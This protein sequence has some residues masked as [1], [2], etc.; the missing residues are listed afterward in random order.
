MSALEVREYVT[1]NGYNP[2]HA[3]LISLKDRQARSRIRTRIDRL[4]LGNF[5]DTKSVGSGVFE[6]RL[7]FGPGYRIYFGQR[8]DQ[9]VLLLCGGDKKSQSDDIRTAHIYWN[10]F[11]SSV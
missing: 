11:R 9:L 3:W 5:G 7:H 6:L 1:N 10:D 8:G 4:S 2:F